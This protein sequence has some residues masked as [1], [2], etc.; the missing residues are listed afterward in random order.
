MNTLVITSP[1][2]QL[3]SP[4]PSGAY[5][6]SFFKVL[7]FNSQWQDLSIK[8]FYEIFSSKGLKKLFAITEKKALQLAEK[9]QF[10]GDE[11]TA[12]NLRNYIFQKD[13]WINWIDWIVSIL[14]DGSKKSGR[15]KAHQFLFSPYVP[16]GNRMRNYLNNLNRSPEV[17]DVRFLCSFA[18][19]DLADYIT[20][21]FDRNFSLIRYAEALTVDERSFSQIE[22][23]LDSPVLNEFLKPVLDN[24]YGGESLPGKLAFG[25]RPTPFSGTHSRNAFE[26]PLLVCISIPFAGTFV[27]GMY[28]AR[29]FKQHF[30]KK[31]FVVI[32]G[33][34]VNTELRNARDKSLSKYLDAISYDRGYGSYKELEDFLVSQNKNENSKNDVSSIYKMRLFINDAVIEPQWENKTAEEFE[35]KITSEIMPDYSDIDFSIYPRVCDD[36]NPMHRLWTDGGWIKA[37]LAHGCYW[38]KCAFCDTQLD[39]VCAYHPVQAEKLY[40]TLLKT[41]EEKGVYGIHFVD[42]ALP[43]KTL[44]DF[45]LMNSKNKNPLYYWGNIRF[46]KSFT[47]D[48]AAFLSYGGLGGVSAGLEVADSNGLQIINKGTDIDSI[49]SACAAFKEA[50]IL[51]HAYMIY[52]FWYDTPQTIIDS[53]ETLRQF[54]AAGLLDSAFWHKFMLTRNSTVY[55]NW[56]DGKIEDL[57]PIEPEFQA[58]EK[59][60][61]DEIF[62]QNNIHFAGEEKYEKF[63]NGLD[64]AVNSWMHGEKLEM[65]VQRWFDFPVPNPTV[66]KNYVEKCI[67][68]YEEKN[69][70][71]IINEKNIDKVY[72][73]G[74]KLIQTG[75]EIKWNYLQEENSRHNLQLENCSLES[76]LE[77]LK[78]ESSRAERENA[79]MTIKK[80]KRLMK[81]IELLHGNGVVVV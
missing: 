59:S 29:Y 2:V 17:D 54:F 81:V 36:S 63:G 80:D 78:P 57:Q 9:A 76:V 45:A 68:K 20:F 3:N 37:Y 12:E 70:S 28:I 46:E 62:A 13:L 58:S 10:S 35:N 27:P 73:L 66:P 14:C 11:I 5:L 40:N 49:V 38:H 23:E 61:N 48:V 47:K 44:C 42:E 16:R 8:L 26:E 22:K 60:E 69:K 71:V 64:A 39:Y 24:L 7:G 51:V 79:V 55:K 25:E 77:G 75:D 18:L 15:E 41:A 30:G 67:E 4:Y 50:G 31:V 65:K 21:V 32:G 19:A 52:G 72:W 33:G 74:G 6:T 1:L 34:F 53:M 43:P 56:Q